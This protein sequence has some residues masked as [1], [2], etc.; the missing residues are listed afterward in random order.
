MRIKNNIKCLV[1][2]LMISSG[3]VNAQDFSLKQA[4]DYAV[5]HYYE[6]VNA[7]LDVQKSKAKIWE[8]TAL[9]LPQVNA[10]GGYR[11]AKDLE[12]NVLLPPGDPG[13]LAAFAAD[14][15]TQGKIEA[16][17]L[18]FDG[19][20]IVGL[21]ASKKYLEF[22]QV[23]K[24]KTDNDVR[25]N[26][27]SSYY[28]VLI[29][30]ENISVLDGSFENLEVSIKETKALVDQGFLDATELD[31]L[32]L[33]KSDL[34]SSLQSAKFTKEV[35]IKMLK[36]NMGIDFSS[37]VNLSDS[38]S[39][40]TEQIDLDVLLSKQFDQESN[41]DLKVL[42]IQRDLKKLDLKRYKA[43]RLPI[44]A[45]YYQ[46]Q[47]TA[48]QFDW[49][50]LNNASWY[51]AQNIGLS[52]SVPLVSSGKQGSIIKQA[53]LELTK[54]ENSLSYAQNAISIQFKNA[55]NNL[56]IK[57]GNLQNTKRSLA[58]A[59]KIYDRTALKQKEGLASSFEL[60]QMKNQV[61]QSQGKY[62]QALFDLLNAKA[63]LDKLQKQ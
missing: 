46:A 9:G 43:Q 25:A 39:G 57:N 63:D 55:Q 10:L 47:T 29:S 37:S 1:V 19:S 4:Q 18:I 60:S 49:D 42:E 21:Q 30:D 34:E 54:M 61:L 26:V 32:E 56:N 36:L 27:A 44:I 58:L 16:T 59:Q 28:L 22:S 5:E 48:Y 40:I 3:V 53:R 38:L 7:G 45:G 20:Y 15:I 33:M 12:F 11:F 51:D 35:A 50:W 62:I 24:E 14:N 8:L 31:Q 2:S 23:G 41:P 13:F 52:I 6:S 17:Q